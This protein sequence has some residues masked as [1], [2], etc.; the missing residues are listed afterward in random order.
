MTIRVLLADDQALLRATFRILID[1][2]PDMEVV[3]EATDGQEAVDLVRVHRP[4]VV[5]MDIRM[6]GTDGLTATAVICADEELADIRVLILTTFEIDEYVAQ[7]LRSGASGFL[8]KDVTAD[9]LLDGI[10][11]VAAGDTLL[12]PA[13]TRTLIT[14]FLATPTPG[15]R[16]AAP[17]RLTI[18][19][20]RERE[21]MSL[22]AEGHSNDEIAEKLYVSPLTVRTHVHRA[23]T[24]LGARDR[25]QLVVM[26]YQSGLVRVTPPE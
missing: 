19:T 16:L 17:D 11:T 8:G 10:R 12:S 24:K 26:A 18:L 15:S 25:A 1:S 9:V 23:M 20:T 3:A 2:C 21:V 5:L 4:D 13:A 14:R 7:A 22:A 6:P